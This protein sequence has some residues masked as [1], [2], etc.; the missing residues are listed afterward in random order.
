MKLVKSDD[1]KK[2]DQNCINE[3]GISEIIL[4]EHAGMSAY[5]YIHESIDKNKKIG[6]VCGG[7]NNGGDGY[8]LAR[9]LH[10]NGYNVYVISMNTETEMSPSCAINYGIVK[11]MNIPNIPYIGVLPECD[12]WVD[13]VFGTGL[14]REVTGDYQNVINQLN[15]SADYIISLDIPSGLDSQSGKILGTCVKANATITFVYPKLGCYL[16]PGYA[17]CGEIIVKDLDIPKQVLQQCN[18][19]FYLNDKEYVKSLLPK[20]FAH[21]HKGTYGNVAVIGGKM[22]M[23]GAL[24]LSAKACFSSGAGKVTAICPKSIQ[25]LMQMK[26][27][28]IMC[29]GIEEKDGYLGK[30]QNELL[31]NFNVLAFGMGAGRG[32]CIH[33][34]AKQILLSKKSCVIDADGIYGIKENLNLLQNENIVLTPHPKEFSYLIGKSVEDVLKNPIQECLD[35]TMKYPVVVVLKM[36]RTIIAHK[37]EIYINHTGNNGLAKGGSGDVLGGM[38]AGFMAQNQNAFDSAKLAV[39]LHGRAADILADKKS[40]YAMKP[41]DIIDILP[42]AFIELIE[43]SK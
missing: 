22:G 37:N 20:R 15:Q 33:N 32:T 17:F 16:F 35:F 42:Q 12:I 4:M 14:N 28:E 29:I 19:N 18:T 30:Y 3:Y 39:Y 10:V 31:E 41:N 21:S 13:A 2:I 24:S 27:D 34:W 1:I 23:C 8:V 40:V 25:P 5:E 36:D 43:A 26:N 7:G 38:I 11:K 6:I 9:L